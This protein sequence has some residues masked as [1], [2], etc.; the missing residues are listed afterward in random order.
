MAGR[1]YKNVSVSVPLFAA[2][3]YEQV[4]GYLQRRQ[5]S[6]HSPDLRNV[7]GHHGERRWQRFISVGSA[8]NTLDDIRARCT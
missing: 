6:R 3:G 2:V 1:F 7:G 8:A 5:W 4:E